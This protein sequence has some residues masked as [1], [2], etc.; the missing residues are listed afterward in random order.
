MVADNAGKGMI[1]VEILGVD[2][3]L[4]SL[5]IKARGESGDPVVT[6]A[7]KT[8]NGTWGALVDVISYMDQGYCYLDVCPAE[9]ENAGA[10]NSIR[11][12]MEKY[13]RIIDVSSHQGVIDWQK[14]KNSG[15]FDGAIIRCGYRGSRGGCGRDSRFQVNALQCQRL[16]IPMG[17]YWFTSALTVD[18]AVQEADYCAKL[19]APYRLSLPVFLD[20][21][22]GSR[23][24]LNELDPAVRTECVI[25]F[26]DRMQK[27]GYQTGI[28]ASAD[29]LRDYMD[30]EKLTSWFLWEASWHGRPGVD[31][32]QAWQYTPLA[33]VPG[34]PG[35]TADLSYWFGW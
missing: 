12:P 6:D 2:E 23:K 17:V 31:G 24:G 18:E 1:S 32:Y 19:I 3:D 28:Y 8:D 26:L 20:T 35:N 29:W 16:G 13:K 27:Y 5:I 10:L 11:V 14:A 9:P 21:E 30:H 15:I 25:A 22:W 34:I 33:Q 7:E 4:S